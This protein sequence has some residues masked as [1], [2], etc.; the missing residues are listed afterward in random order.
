MSEAYIYDD[1]SPV[2]GPLTRVQALSE[3]MTE[4]AMYHGI[5]NKDGNRPED[6]SPLLEALDRFGM[7]LND[8]SSEELQELDVI[9]G[10]LYRQYLS[11]TFGDEADDFEVTPGPEDPDFWIRLHDRMGFRPEPDP[12]AA[13]K[14]ALA[15]GAFVQASLETGG[16]ILA[17]KP[18]GTIVEAIR[19]SDGTHEER[20]EQ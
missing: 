14:N 19:R 15:T 13:L 1:Y 4:R 18:D 5:I 17:R 9:E 6:I 7:T 3:V 20:G 2:H 8:L 12:N 10:G 11:D 16:A